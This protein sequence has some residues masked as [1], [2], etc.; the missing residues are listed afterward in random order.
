MNT[1]VDFINH[2]CCREYARSSS[3]HEKD[4]NNRYPEPPPAI[5]YI[6]SP[7]VSPTTITRAESHHSPACQVGQ[8]VVL[9]SNTDDNGTKNTLFSSEQQ[10]GKEN[11]SPELVREPRG[12]RSRKENQVEFTHRQSR[13][14]SSTRRPSIETSLSRSSSRIPTLQVVLIVAREDERNP[15]SW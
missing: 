8:H 6:D 12:C 1:Y 11:I 3:S 15:Y 2:T 10:K 9:N 13:L 7:E 5:N 14:Q 4:K